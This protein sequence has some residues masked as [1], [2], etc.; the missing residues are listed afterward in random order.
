MKVEP[1]RTLRFGVSISED[2][3]RQFDQWVSEKGF[4]NR[5]E[6]LRQMIRKE[7][8][9]S[10]WEAEK[11]AVWG[12]VT[13]YYDHHSHD[14]SGSITELQ[15]DHGSAII[16]T[17]HVHVDHDHCLE[18]IILNGSVQQIKD[19]LF[20]LSKMKGIESSMPVISSTSIDPEANGF[21]L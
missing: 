14:V 2:L 3:L 13:L 1:E 19:F 7:I 12:T 8:A 11:G 15:H 20:D 10:H 6:A 5:S 4:P 16:C 17:T 21:S 18:V 9:R